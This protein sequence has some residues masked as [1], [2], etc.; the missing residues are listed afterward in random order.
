MT[1]HEKIKEM[2]KKQGLTQE[3]M[4]EAM[5]ICVS[6]YANLENGKSNI[7]WNK[8]QKIAEIFNIDIVQL[9]EAEKK[10]LIV[11]QTLYFQEQDNQNHNHNTIYSGNSELA[12]ELEKRDLTINHLRELL[13]QKDKQIDTLNDLINSLKKQIK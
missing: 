5:D 1:I 3:K 9:I 8:L 4:A 2:G 13:E 11:Q 7:D 10:G 12:F 6:N